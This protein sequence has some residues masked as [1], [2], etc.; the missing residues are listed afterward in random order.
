[1][2][3]NKS[4]QNLTA[5]SNQFSQL[6]LTRSSNETS[7]GTDGSQWIIEKRTHSKYEYIDRWSLELNQNDTELYNFCRSMMELIEE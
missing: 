3:Q 7:F 1:M 4:I 6:K 2:E 5:I